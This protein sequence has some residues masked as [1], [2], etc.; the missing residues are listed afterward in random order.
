MV[1]KIERREELR[2]IKGKGY[3]YINHKI[4]GAFFFHLIYLS[5]TNTDEK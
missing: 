1:A 5:G 2:K 4:I 3:A